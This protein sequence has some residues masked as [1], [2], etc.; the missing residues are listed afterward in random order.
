MTM[1]SVRDVHVDAIMTNI[2]VAYRNANYIGERI[3]PR[4]SV[5]KKSDS[6]F[7]YPKSAWLRDE[8]KTR[9]PG[10][11][12]NRGDYEI[13]TSS[14]VALTYAIAKLV[15]DEVRLNADAPLRPDVEATEWTVDQLLRAQERRIAL[16]TTGGSA[17]WAY[18]ASP[19]TQW[20]SDVSDPWGDIDNAINGVVGSIGVF[21]NTFVCSW[22]VWRHL[23]QHPDFLDRVKYQREGGR[24]ETSDISAWFNL[25]NVL[26]GT[27]LYDAAKEGQ[28]SSPTMIWGDAVWIGYVTPSPALMTPSA[29]YVFEWQNREV[30]RYRLDTNH[31]DLIEAQH[32]VDE[33]ISASDAAGVLYNTV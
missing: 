3:F 32:S 2:S 1:P 29:G 16:L 21:P 18:A 20:S 17:L 31:A 10:T 25:P 9:A 11:E 12:A 19:T 22:D 27:Q 15:P 4:V 6:Y 23:R 33:V 14:Y 8:V 26:V 7:V 28:T 30:R 24:V 13:T 5:A